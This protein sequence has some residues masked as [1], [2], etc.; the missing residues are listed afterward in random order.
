MKLLVQLQRLGSG[1]V[2]YR[3]T[4]G[5]GAPWDRGFLDN[6]PHIHLLLRRYFIGYIP[7]VDGRN[8][9]NH[10]VYPFIPL[11]MCGVIGFRSRIFSIN[12]IIT[13]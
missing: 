8:L 7:T 12:T 13:R 10:L 6:Q 3:G 9:A 2:S 1:E 5:T 11:F 4:W